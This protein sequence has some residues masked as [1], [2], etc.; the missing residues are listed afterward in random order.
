MKNLK[1]SSAFILIILGLGCFFYFKNNQKHT[2]IA[3]RGPFNSKP[4]K[5][6]TTIYPSQGVKKIKSHFV[7]K[8]PPPI[9]IKKELQPFITDHAIGK[10]YRL[11]KGVK[12]LESKKYEPS[13]GK[14]LDE[15]AGFIF[16]LPSKKDENHPMPAAINK[17]NQKLYAVSQVFH[18][19]K[20]S[21]NERLKLKNQ[22][23]Q[24]Y[25]Y[26]SR[27][28]LMSIINRPEDWEQ[29]Y[30]NLLA[31]GYKVKAEVLKEPNQIK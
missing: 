14:K 8:E 15:H 24:E 22:G 3:Y 13:F 5:I 12:A 18:L 28:K 1:K 21:Q 11:L 25:Y 23:H 6:V 7:F 9:E 29:K 20:I 16:Y 31:Q 10:S 27:L 2:Q 17:S 26:H 4:H 19:E 30:T